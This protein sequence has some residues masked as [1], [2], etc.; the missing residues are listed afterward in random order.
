MSNYVALILSLANPVAVVAGSTSEQKALPTND[1]RRSPT[2]CSAFDPFLARAT[3][4]PLESDNSNAD[5]SGLLQVF[6]RL[7]ALES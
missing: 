3:R 7:E 1:R 4:R 5:S 6:I 2:A